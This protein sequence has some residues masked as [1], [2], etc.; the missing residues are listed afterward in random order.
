VEPGLVLHREND[1]FSLGEPDGSRSDRIVALAQAL[2]EAGLNVPIR[3][4]LRSEIWTKLWGNAVFNPLSALTHATLGEMAGGP[5][6]HGFVRTAM[7]EVQVV[8][9]SLGEEMAIDV[10]TRM[11]GSA[12]VGSHKTSMLQDLEAGRPLEISAL[13]GAVVEIGRITGVETPNL[14]ALNGMT[15]LLAANVLGQT[16]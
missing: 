2:I 15:R 12:R 10:D 4:R 8:A 7:L 13:T 14:N 11:A 1:R 3:P 16:V 9:N 6:V 5:E